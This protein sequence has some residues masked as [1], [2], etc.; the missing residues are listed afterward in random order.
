MDFK[1]LNWV[2]HCLSLYSTFTLQ[3]KNELAGTHCGPVNCNYWIHLLCYN[4]HSFID[5]HVTY[6]DIIS[7]N[8]MSSL[9]G[10]RGAPVCLSELISAFLHSKLSND[11]KTRVK[12]ADCYQWCWCKYFQNVDP[13]AFMSKMSLPF[14]QDTLRDLLNNCNNEKKHSFMETILF[15]L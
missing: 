15:S 6:K 14:C 1:L 7:V 8:N 5:I 13:I 12:P 10:F 11:R 4:K 3:L 9:L 2:G